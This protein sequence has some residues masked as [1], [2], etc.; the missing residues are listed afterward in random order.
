MKELLELLRQHG[1]NFEI[2]H[3]LKRTITGYD[4]GYLYLK[5][6]KP[7]KKKYFECELY[8]DSIDHNISNFLCSLVNI[9]VM[10]DENF[11]E[12]KNKD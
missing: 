11:K 10:D 5:I 3:K 9:M 7:D 6:S 2:T 12:D 4:I 8:R 1:L